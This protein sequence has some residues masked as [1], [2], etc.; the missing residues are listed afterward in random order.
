MKIGIFGGSFNPVHKGHETALD[1]FIRHAELDMVYVIPTFLP[2]HKDIPGSW[3]S[4]EDRMNMLR[5]AVGDRKEV[6]ISDIEKR[7]FE[8]SGEKSYT[9]I[10]LEHLKNQCV[11]EYYL[12]VGTDMFTTLHLWREPHYI[13]DNATIAVMSRDGKEESI[14]NCKAEFEKIFNARITIIPD[15]HT[16]ASSTE[17]RAALKNNRHTDLLSENVC[18][19]IAKNRLYTP[20]ITL[21]ELRE[22][23]KKT[24]PEK[25]YL[26]TL[27]VEKETKYLA[28]LLCPQFE[29]ELSRAALLHDITKYL[30]TE[31]HITLSG[32]LDENDLKSPETLH[33]VTGAVTAR[34]MG[35]SMWRTIECHT[36]GKAD[37]SVFDMIIFVADYTEETR[38]HTSCISER[39]L[40]HNALDSTENKSE[41][42]AALRQSVLRILDNTVSYLKQK[43]VFIHPRTLDALE[44]YRTLTEEKNEKR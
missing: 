34:N 8:K 36:T 37:M 5:C 28:S 7:L 24:L 22:Y 32:S 12:Y 20:K 16:E 1:A 10:T 15:C 17:V 9:K 2:P 27:A 42:I 33:A 38:T 26:H 4:F 35:E 14:L 40:L 18:A 43:D 11:G 3:A 29:E 31:E 25:R 21:N 44:Y 41:R 39:K 6:I 19:Y 13:F 30:S 23:V